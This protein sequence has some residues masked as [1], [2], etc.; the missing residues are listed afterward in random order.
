[1]ADEEEGH[2]IEEFEEDTLQLELHEDP[3]RASDVP[4]S[5]SRTFDDLV[6]LDFSKPITSLGI[7]LEGLARLQTPESGINL[8][9]QSSSSVIVATTRASEALIVV[10]PSSPLTTQGGASS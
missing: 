4:A 5:S 6:N 2:E 3:P 10:D 9:E 1:M 8:L 7:S